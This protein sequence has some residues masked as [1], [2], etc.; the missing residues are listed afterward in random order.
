MLDSTVAAL[1]PPSIERDLGASRAEIQWVLNGY[2]LVMAAL[3]VSDRGR[4][5]RRR[6]AADLLDQRPALRDR[7][8]HRRHGR[9]REPRR[10]RDPSDRRPRPPPAERRPDGGRAAPGGV[11]A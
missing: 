3:V 10:D 8:R 4:P 2:L 6:L 11:R 7:S 5:R 1:A 9:A